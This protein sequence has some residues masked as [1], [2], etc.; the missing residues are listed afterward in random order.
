MVYKAKEKALFAPIRIDVL[1]SGMLTAEEIGLYATMLSRTENWEFSEFVLAR[2]LKTT[3]EEI[4]HLLKRLEQKG[5]TRERRGRYGTVWDLY[6][7]SDQLPKG[8]TQKDYTVPQSVAKAFVERM[9][10]QGAHEGAVRENA[11]MPDEANGRDN[12]SDM[13]S[14][15]PM[16]REGNGNVP[17]TREEIGQ[18]LIDLRQRCGRTRSKGT[19]ACRTDENPL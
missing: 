12:P 17:M 11:S 16:S 5:F 4:R 14:E 8:S 3:P 2:E 15:P 10:Q 1:R 18:K 13:Q 19:Q 6:E 7:L 9:M